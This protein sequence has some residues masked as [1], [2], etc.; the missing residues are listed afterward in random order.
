SPLA[1][2]AA[3]VTEEPRPPLRA[4][5]LEPVL[6]GLL[7]KDPGLRASAR[8]TEAELARI[9]TPQ[10]EAYPRAQP[11]LGSRPPWETAPH[12]QGPMRTCVPS[13]APTRRRRRP[14]ALR[15]VLAGGLG[16]LLTLGGTW[17]A[18]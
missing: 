4:G 5:A 12:P 15:A 2:V 9:V 6:R 13:P 14:H 18:L 11:E 3:V 16:L 10:S 17:Y 7:A 1:S 8:D